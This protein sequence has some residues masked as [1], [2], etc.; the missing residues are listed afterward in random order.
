NPERPITEIQF[1]ATGDALVAYN[2]GPAPIP[3]GMDFPGAQRNFTDWGQI[4]SC[5]GAPAAVPDHPVCQ[6]FP[7]CEGGVQTTLCTRQ[8]GSHCGNYGA[9]DIANVAWGVFERAALP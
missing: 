4:N 8:G 6:T 3:Q 9:L 7:A 5:T 2:G 1:R